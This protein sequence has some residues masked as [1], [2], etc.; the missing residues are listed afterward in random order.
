M[1][2]SAGYQ[3]IFLH[4]TEFLRQSAALQV[5]IIRQLLAV[6]RNIKFPAAPLQR[7]GV[8]VSHHPTT[9]GLWRGMKASPGK[10]QIFVHGDRQKICDVLKRPG[11]RSVLQAL[12]SAAAKEENTTIF[13]CG[14][15]HER[16]FVFQQRVGFCE[17]LPATDMTDDRA[18]APG[19]IALNCYAPIENKSHLLRD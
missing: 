16:G 3:T 13:A 5:Q 6:K 17:D 14:H 19:V 8:E 18:V 12:N 4:F 11:I 10:D 15:I 7:N 1:I 2:F 9:D